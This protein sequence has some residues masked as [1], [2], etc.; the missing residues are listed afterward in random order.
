MAYPLEAKLLTLNPFSRPGKKLS[1]V[2]GVV[3]HWIGNPGTS[4]L[5]NR[6]YFEGLKAQSL[7]NPGAVFA[8][9]HFIAG[10][11][12]EVIQCIPLGEAAYHVGAKQYT[13]EAISRFGHYPN[14]GTIGIELCHPVWDGK[15][16]PETW[17]SA[18]ELAA[19]L[20]KRFNLRPADIW[21]HHGI[22]RKDCPKYFVEHPEAFGQFRLDVESAMKKSQGVPEWTY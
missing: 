12:G 7:N 9:A 15:F 1:G 8:S 16:T 4:A 14:N 2:K 6:N 10:L 18:V 5:Q 3:I 22:T 13:P 17:A 11:R 20:L 19:A 21:T